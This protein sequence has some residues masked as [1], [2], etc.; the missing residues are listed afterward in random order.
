MGDDN[1]DGDRDNGDEQR[2]RKKGKKLGL[3]FMIFLESNAKKKAKM[4][5]HN[6]SKT[7]KK[8]KEMPTKRHRKGQWDSSGPKLDP[9]TSTLQE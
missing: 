4:N 7:G 9:A 2:R 6:T 5:T 3:G 1:D 8:T